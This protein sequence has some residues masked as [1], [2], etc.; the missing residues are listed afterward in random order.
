[1]IISQTPL[2][3]SF[4]GG[5]TDFED[6]YRQYPGRVLSTT[7]DKYY[8]VSLNPR[9]DGAIKAVYSEIELV[10]NRSQIKHPLIRAALE[11]VGIENGL[12]INFLSD[13]PAKKTGTGLGSSSS[14]TVGLLNCLY[15]L[16]NKYL[17]PSILAEKACD[18]EI[19]KAKSPIGKQDQYIVAFGGLNVINFNCDGKIYLSPKIKNDFQNH[20]LLFFTGTERL[21]NPILSEQRQNIANKLDSLKKISDCV[22]VFRS[23][24]EK[25]EFKE[26][27]EILNQ[28]WL[29][30]R[31]LSSGISNPQIEEMYNL[32]MNAGA[33]G[34]KVLG[35][36]GGGFLLVMA[37]S[38][39]HLKIK[40]ALI[41]YK[42]IPFNFSE[43]GSRIVFKN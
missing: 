20:L 16:S 18:V 14:F 11:D 28:N 21:A 1:M 4:V 29:M 35:A 37:P 27:G 38:E 10:D 15:A 22:L 33:F 32:A 9:F 7:I 8:Y 41:N 17:S 25:G 31:Q 12:D 23:F 2:R 40:E 34:C 26:A 13:L 42:L 36:G 43:A 3:I 6:F 39:K 19:N 5:G 24:L 30:K